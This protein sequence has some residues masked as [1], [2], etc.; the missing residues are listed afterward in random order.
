MKLRLNIAA[1][2]ILALAVLGCDK[3]KL[4]DVTTPP[5]AAHFSSDGGTYFITSPTAKFTIPVGLTTPSNK[6]VTLNISVSSPTGA[7][8]GTYYTLDKT[9]VVIPAGKA[10]DSVVVSG[11]Y[12]QYLSG[13][14][15]SLIF[16]IQTNSDVAP[17][18]FNSTYKLYMRGPCFDGDVTDITV[19]NGT[20]ANSTDPDDPKFTATVSNITKTGPTTATGTIANLW[21]WFGPVTINFDWTDPN[22]TIVS[23]PLQQTNQVYAAGQPFLIRTSPGK[24][25]KFSVCT[26]QIPMIVD[27]IVNNYPSAG[28]AAYYHQNFTMTIKR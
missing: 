17:A 3:T 21:D 16:T 14:K 6:D 15:D 13:R 8:S 27:I 9:T 2:A 23:I 5:L 19:M 10:L 26:G 18:N 20:Y 22:N 4:F 1:I 11:V 25:S 7:T 12:S 28:S 24:V